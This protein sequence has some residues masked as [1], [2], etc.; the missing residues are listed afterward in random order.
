MPQNFLLLQIIDTVLAVVDG[1]APA[2]TAVLE[3]A[4]RSMTPEDAAILHD[5]LFFSHHP[6][7]MLVRSSNCTTSFCRTTKVD[8]T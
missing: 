8:V 5:V 3:G 4:S 6:K 7:E 1:V 2:N